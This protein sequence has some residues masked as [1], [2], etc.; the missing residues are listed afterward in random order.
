MNVDKS[1]L[2]EYNSKK[3]IMCPENP[4]EKY[5]T[6]KEIA[7]CKIDTIEL[8]TIKITSGDIV[9]CDPTSCLDHQI[10]PFFD[11]F[12]KPFDL[13]M[14]IIMLAIIQIFST[15]I[16]TIVSF[17]LLQMTLPTEVFKGHPTF[18]HSN[19]INQRKKKIRI[20]TVILIGFIALLSLTNDYFYLHSNNIPPLRISHRGVDDGNGVQ[21]TIPAMAATIKEHPDFIEIICRY[22]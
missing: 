3:S 21:N 20:T 7:G 16:A 4:L 11:K 6:D 2:D 14:A 8:G 10:S 17:L 13:I 9:A 22:A 18:Y 5:F 15:F 12:P 1:W 19:R